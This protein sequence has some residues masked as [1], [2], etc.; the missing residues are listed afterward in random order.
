M[1]KLSLPSIKPF[2][3]RPISTFLNCVSAKSLVEHAKIVDQ[4]KRDNE[5]VMVEWRRDCEIVDAINKLEFRIRRLEKLIDNP[6][7]P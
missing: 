4:M 5:K 3:G 2:P 1:K 7:K 6:V